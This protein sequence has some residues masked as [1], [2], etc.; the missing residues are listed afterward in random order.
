[1]PI[2]IGIDPSINST[3]ICINGDILINYS[4]VDVN[5]K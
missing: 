3:A 4:T 2:K 5:N 1:M